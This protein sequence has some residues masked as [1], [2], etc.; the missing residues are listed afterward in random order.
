MKMIRDL[1]GNKCG[2][3]SVIREL[4][5][6]PIHVFWVCQC[7]CGNVVAVREDNLKSGNTKSCGCLRQELLKSGLNTR[8]LRGPTSD[9]H[10][11]WA[12]HSNE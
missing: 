2:R 7:D 10:K 11:A 8:K 9:R 12:I 3:L 5:R 4:A 1:A 6:N